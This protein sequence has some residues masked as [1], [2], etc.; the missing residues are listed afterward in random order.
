MMAKKA[1]LFN[2]YFYYKKI[3]ANTNPS[4]IKRLGKKIRNFDINVWNDNKYQIILEGNYLKFS[5][6]LKL[7][8]KILETKNKIIAE[9][10][11][12]DNIYGIGL[13]A[14]CA[15]NMDPNEWPGENLLGKALM[16]VRSMLQ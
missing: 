5:Q 6:N 14:K 11:P 15:I 13:S 16:E 9:A 4:E 1:L 2:D 3:M 7:K 10:S 12:Y 8:K